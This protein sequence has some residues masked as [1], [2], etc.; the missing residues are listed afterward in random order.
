MDGADNKSITFQERTPLEPVQKGS[1]GA[2]QAGV[3]PENRREYAI[4][5]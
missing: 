2:S 5:A 1:S 3:L 4:K